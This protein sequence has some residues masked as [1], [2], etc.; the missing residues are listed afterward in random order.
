MAAFPKSTLILMQ[1][2]HWPPPI[3]FRRN[4]SEEEVLSKMSDI[5]IILKEAMA[6]ALKGFHYNIQNTMRDINGNSI[7]LKRRFAFT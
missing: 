6:T 5:G 2:V 7:N 3:S 1:T 4:I